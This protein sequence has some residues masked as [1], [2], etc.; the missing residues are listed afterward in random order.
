[1]K[2]Q[3]LARFAG[4]YGDAFHRV[5]ALSEVDGRMKVLDMKADVVRETVLVSRQSAA[6]VYRSSIAVEYNPNKQ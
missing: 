2:L 1:M 6:D 4:V 5:E 3:A